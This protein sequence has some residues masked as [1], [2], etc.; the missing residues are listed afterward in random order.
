MQKNTSILYFVLHSYGLYTDGCISKGNKTLFT[1]DST[2]IQRN[3]KLNCFSVELKPTEIEAIVHLPSNLSQNDIIQLRTQPT[4]LTLQGRSQNALKIYASVTRN[5]I[6][7]YQNS[8]EFKKISF[9]VVQNYDGFYN[10][11]ATKPC[12]ELLELKIHLI[13]SVKFQFHSETHRFS[14]TFLEWKISLLH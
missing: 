6:A 7:S 5:A 14:Q 3:I 8:A 9:A 13:Q 10:M 11:Y 4:Q 2:L 12:V 1:A